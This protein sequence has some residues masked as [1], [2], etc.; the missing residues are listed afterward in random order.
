MGKRKPG[1]IMIAELQLAEPSS[2]TQFLSSQ[3]YEVLSVP[4]AAECLD[5]LATHTKIGWLLIDLQA[6][7][8]C[9]GL[10]LARQVL[11]QYDLPL[12]FMD[13]CLKRDALK[14]IADLSYYGFIQ[15]NGNPAV[16]LATLANAQ[17]LHRTF[18]EQKLNSR[19]IKETEA[20]ISGVIDAIPAAVFLHPLVAKDFAPFVNVNSWACIRYGYPRSEFLKLTATDISA[21]QDAQN[22]G[23]AAHR[24]DLLEKKVISFKATHVTRD[25]QHFP[26]EIRSRIIQTNGVDMILS[27]ASDITEQQAYLDSIEASEKRFREMADLLPEAIFETDRDLRLTFHNRRTLS[28]FGYESADDLLG[29][30]ILEWLAPEDHEKFAQLLEQ[31]LSGK[32]LEPIEFRGIR[33]DG[34]SFPERIQVDLIRN[35]DEVTGF[36]GV[37]IDLTQEK[38]HE[39]EMR[40]SLALL[41]SLVQTAAVLIIGL[42]VDGNLTRFNSFAETLTGY[43]AEEVRGQNW[44]QLFIPEEDRKLIPEVF[45]DVLHELPESA[46]HENTILTR[47]GEQKLIVWNNTVTRDEQGE[48]TGVISIGMDVSE[49]RQIEQEQQEL[50]QFLQTV[51]DGVSENLMVINR[52]YSIALANQ[53]VRDIAA[54]N[55]LACEG[56]TCHLVTHG[57]PEPCSASGHSCPLQTVFETRQAAKVEHTLTDAAGR[58]YAAEIIA[59]PI[60]DE[61]GE[62]VQIIEST[63]DV[64]DRK[65]AAQV[66]KQSEERYRTFFE[67][68]EVVILLVDPETGRIEFA[69]HAASKFYGYSREQ[70]VGMHIRRINVLPAEEIAER[71]AE[72]RAQDQNYSIFQHRLA[73]GTLKDVEVYQSKILLQDRDVFSIIV[74]DISD[75][76][77][78]QHEKEALEKQVLH[79]Q[80]LESLGL[81]AG[82]IAHDFNNL[83]TGILGNADLALADLSHLSPIRDNILDIEKAARSAADLAKQ[84]LAYSGKGRFVIEILHLGELVEEMA[85]IL[86]ASISKRAKLKIETG[87]ALPG[88]KGD[89]TQIRQIIMNLITNASESL[90]DQDG[91]ITLTTGV[92]DCDLDYLNQ[93]LETA[94]LLQD[95]PLPEGPYVFMEVA[96]TGCGMDQAILAK[97][98]DPFFTTKFTGRGLGMAAVLGIIR[99]HQAAIKIYTEVGRGTTFKVLFPA[100]DTGHMVTRSEQ[101]SEI[102]GA[103][104]SGDGTVLIVDDE[105]AVRDVGSRMLKRWGYAVL[106][107]SDGQE[108]LEIYQQRFSEIVCVLLD[109]TMPR[110]DGE[111]TFRELRRISQ[112]VRVILCSGYNEQEATQHFIGK[113]LAGFLKKPYTMTK[114]KQKIQEILA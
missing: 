112:N 78:M 89:A 3:G 9:A 14:Q 54:V 97:L 57:L 48:L 37:I 31:R 69:N 18:A 82:G 110:M 74:V 15:R 53:Q 28:L 92:M 94:R 19:R 93:G 7:E 35:G 24:Q 107:A 33:R 91:M 71:M 114:L 26:V 30:N 67:N 77:K 95:D 88:I 61:H 60:L 62:V 47:S 6:F 72:A 21:P 79:V 16:L 25:K 39:G 104:L 87:T 52:D 55:H 45:M 4:T 106:T 109:L 70:L 68:N 41:E 98:F 101:T 44:F 34:S 56:N 81:L 58:S 105:V 10:D 22:R 46:T 40:Q 111:E 90:Q 64:S 29:H 59:T 38:Q 99:G 100:V 96:D 108:A 8:N 63:R 12:L 51:V 20:R 103:E 5:Q 42:D 66:L 113:G 32:Q 23:A 17:R 102:E 27:V 75:R 85:H 65:T 50:H 76:L 1:T 83:L 36:R 73:D 43:T 13:S 80:K 2:E 84:M 11:K 86:E 49:Q